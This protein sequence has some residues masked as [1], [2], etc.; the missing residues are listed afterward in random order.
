MKSLIYRNGWIYETSI[1]LMHGNGR[2]EFMGQLIG[3]GKRVLE[4]GCG[5]GLL[6]KCIQKES[7][8][9][10]VDLNSALVNYGRKR[11][12]NCFLGDMNTAPLS[13]DVVVLID[14]LHHIPNPD[15]FLKRIVTQ[16]ET[17]VCEPYDTNR[18]KYEKIDNCLIRFLFSDDDG[19]NETRDNWFDKGGLIEFFKSCGECDL[20]EFNKDIIGWY[21]RPGI[22]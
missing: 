7:S 2:Y 22:H 13:C 18:T 4:L 5:T 9:R 3:N 12:R 8:Y 15:D 21:K 6:Q 10:G 11:G 17:I 14:V 16:R 20:F 1:K 19:I